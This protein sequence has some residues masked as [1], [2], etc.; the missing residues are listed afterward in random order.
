MLY[1]KSSYMIV[2]KLVFDE[3]NI[4]F[5]MQNYPPKKRVI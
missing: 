1:N 2:L 3:M 4:L 5:Y